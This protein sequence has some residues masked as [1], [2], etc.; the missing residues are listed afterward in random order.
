[1]DDEIQ[2]FFR[3][4]IAAVGSMCYCY[5]IAKHIPS[6]LTRL[7]SLLPI[8]YLLTILPFSL[9]SFHLGAPT[10]FYLVWLANFKLLLFTFDTG[11]L[12]HPTH[13]PI[14]LLHFVSTA[15]LPIKL[16]PDPNP[17]LNPDQDPKASKNPVKLLDPASSGAEKLQKWGIGAAKVVLLVMVIRIY[18]YREYLHPYVMLGLYCCHVYLGVELVLALTA[19]PVR[20]FLGL[21][22]EPQFHDPYLSTSLQD[23]WGRRWNLVVTSIL[24]PT[25]YCP[26]RSLSMPVLGRRWAS[27]PAILANFLVSGLMHE[28]LFYYFTR[29]K[30]TW[31]VTL[32]FVVHGGCTA[33]EVVSKKAVAV[34]YGSIPAVNCGLCSGDW[35]LVLLPAD[36]KEQAGP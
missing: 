13:K 24:R 34:A 2:N 10:A 26:V 14:S 30:P 36:N 22:L 5:F 28:L 19:V 6:G 12:S 29:A 23:F 35:S 16:K 4:W 31:E 15:L 3:V 20:A 21:E 1:M 27:L 11:P 18:G 9:H 33:V 25:V 17:K 32:F 8:F 7:F